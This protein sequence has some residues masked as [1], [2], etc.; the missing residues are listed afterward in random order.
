[1]EALQSLL[2]YLTKTTGLVADHK[3]E[4]WGE[5]GKFIFTPG[6]ISMGYEVV[7]TANFE[8]SDVKVDPVKFGMYFV[9]WMNVY[10]PDREN[11]GLG[12][13]EFFVEPLSGGK[14]DLGLRLQFREQISLIEDPA[15]EWLLDDGKKYKASSDFGVAA[16]LSLLEIVDSHTQDTGLKN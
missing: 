11:H 8:M 2:T 4:A 13:P 10:I 15:G 7:Y 14:F 5:D 1:M 3:I 12:E 6:I 9:H 16:D